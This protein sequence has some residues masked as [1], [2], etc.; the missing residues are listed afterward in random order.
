LG[1]TRKIKT[2]TL[3]AGDMMR[4]AMRGLIGLVG[5][6]NL[7]LGVGFLLDPLKLGTAFFL[8]PVGTQGLAT[9]RGDFPGFFIGASLFALFGA[10]RTKADVLV[11][12]LIMLAIADAGRF[13]GL[14]VDGASSTAFPPMIAEWIMIALLLIGYRTF[15]GATR[16]R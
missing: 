16:A 2:Y 9:L 4:T 7:V 13:V 3:E 1:V 15:A 12:P 10:Y 11:V 5:I 6:F 14:I 8:S